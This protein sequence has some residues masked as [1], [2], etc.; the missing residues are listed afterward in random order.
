MICLNKVQ[1]KILLIVCYF[2]YFFSFINLIFLLLF[3]SD[4]GAFVAAY[5]EH[6]VYGKNIAT[7]FDIEV[8]RSSVA[9]SLYSYGMKKIR[10]EIISDSEQTLKIKKRRL[11]K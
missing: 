4:C 9:Y 7:T 2:F 1:I 8:Y 10:G 11:K 3:C 6:I 5:A